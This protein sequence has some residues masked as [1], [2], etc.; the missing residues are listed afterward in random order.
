MPASNCPPNKGTYIYLSVQWRLQIAP[1]T[2]TGASIEQNTGSPRVI[3]KRCDWSV[4]PRESQWPEHDVRTVVISVAF[5]AVVYRAH[6][7]YRVLLY[8]TYIHLC[9]LKWVTVFLLSQLY[10]VNNTQAV[11]MHLGRL[12]VRNAVTYGPHNAVCSSSRIDC[13]HSL[14]M[15]A[16]QNTQN[17][18]PSH[19]LTADPLGYKDPPKAIR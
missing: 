6:G 10:V 1:R 3:W 8:S 14:V 7:E 16:N 19:T 9:W 4:D 12:G 2:S 15:A 5:Y 18:P 11:Q 17:W 13:S